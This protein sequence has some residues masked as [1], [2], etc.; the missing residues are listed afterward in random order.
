MWRT[1]NTGIF[2]KSCWILH[3]KSV[4]ARTETTATFKI[5]TFQLEHKMEKGEI[6]TGDGTKKQKERDG[7]EEKE[8]GV[9][10]DIVK[11]FDKRE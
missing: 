9:Q 6:K 5:P 1:T 3:E 11:K 2:H 4:P 10:L 7:E 8:E